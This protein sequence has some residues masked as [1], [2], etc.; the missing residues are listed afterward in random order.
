MD[1]WT[2]LDQ[3]SAATELI[4]ARIVPEFI[5]GALATVIDAR[6]REASCVRL[7]AAA[8]VMRACFTGDFRSVD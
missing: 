6:T 5:G 2:T 1:T 4:R 8:C 3:L 7:R